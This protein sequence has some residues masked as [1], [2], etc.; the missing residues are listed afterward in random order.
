MPF[1]WGS[2]GVTTLS[3][4]TIDCDLVIPT[5]FKVTT[6]HIDETTPGHG[7]V[8][9]NK[10]KVDHI[11]EATAAHK[12]VADN[13]LAAD[14]IAEGSAGHGIMHD[15]NLLV[16]QDLV[17]A[18]RN[19]HGGVLYRDVTADTTVVSDND[20]CW[21]KTKYRVGIKKTIAANTYVSKVLFQIASPGTCGGAHANTGTW[22]VQ[23]RRVDTDAIIATSYE[24]PLNVTDIAAAKTNYTFTFPAPS[25]LY[26]GDVYIA[27]EFTG[28]TDANAMDYW[29]RTADV[30]LPMWYYNGAW[31]GAMATD[32]LS[33]T[34][35]IATKTATT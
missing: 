24:G 26:A 31:Q 33:G 19:L 12:I 5:A 3:R 34:L 30:T 13:V 23:I 8:A 27:M 11:A 29:R 16:S 4:L 22:L 9:D 20:T 1:P 6:D 35:T 2:A 14:H 32:S 18:S 25:P 7:I 15:S 10:V 17:V 21:D 28:W